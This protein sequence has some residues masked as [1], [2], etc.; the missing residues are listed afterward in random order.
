MFPLYY[1]HSDSLGKFKSSITQCVSYILLICESHLHYLMS[2]VRQQSSLSSH[3][4]R[5]FPHYSDTQDPTPIINSSLITKQTIP[6]TRI[7]ETLLQ[8]LEDMFHVNK[9][10]R[11]SINGHHHLRRNSTKR[12]SVQVTR[13]NG[14]DFYRSISLLL[15]C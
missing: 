12:V 11:L 2:I 9:T 5:Y 8:T 3:K 15:C 14:I 1:M 6:E 7:Q 4:S 13:V 10:K